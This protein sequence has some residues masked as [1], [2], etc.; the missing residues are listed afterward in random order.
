MNERF[1][2]KTYWIY[3]TRACNLN[4]TYCYQPDKKVTGSAESLMNSGLFM[5]DETV[6]KTVEF[7]ISDDPQCRKNVQFFGGEPLL[8]WKTIQFFVEKLKN[9]ARFSVTTN[10]TLLDVEKLDF[11]K[12]NSFALALSLDGPPGVT[13]KTRPGSEN[14]PIDLVAEFFPDTQIIITLSPENIEDA[15]RSTLWFIEMGFR[16]IAHNLALEKP[17]PGWAVNAHRKAFEQLCDHYIEQKDKIG[18]MFINF[19][20]KVIRNSNSRHTRNICGSNP[21]LLSIDINGDIYPCQDMVTCDREKRYRLGNVRTGY[22]KPV[23]LPLSM[24]DF[25]DRRSCRKC[26][27]YHQCVGGCGPKNLLICGDRFRPT[28]NGCELYAAQVIEG[29]RALLNTGQLALFREM[30]IER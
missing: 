13:R 23:R 14:V 24:M 2:K 3:P 9:N 5:D 20:N 12:S 1:E 26:W 4:C 10:G 22:E 19:A 29:I 30:R 6:E 21:Y 28:L 27:F 11:L 16:S 17:W 25:P 15:Y 8:A 7:I 18:Y